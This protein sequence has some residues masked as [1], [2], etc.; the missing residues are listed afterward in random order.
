MTMKSQS[1][2]LQSAIFHEQSTN[3]LA[4]M[5]SSDTTFLVR[6]SLLNGLSHTF[7]SS[8]GRMGLRGGSPFRGSSLG[9][10]SGG[11]NSVGGLMVVSAVIEQPSAIEWTICRPI[12]SGQVCW[13]AVGDPPPYFMK[14]HLKHLWKVQSLQRSQAHS[15]VLCIL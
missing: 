8:S 13:K 3:A 7:G 2:P 15:R 12:K 11:S 5:M 10:C 6:D 1:K 14:Y 9:A 4:R